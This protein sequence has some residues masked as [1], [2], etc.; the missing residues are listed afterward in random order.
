MSNRSPNLQ[1][2]KRAWDVSRVSDSHDAWITWFTH[3]AAQ[4]A[5]ES[6][7]VSL[8]SCMNLF[9]IYPDISIQLFNPALASCW[10][11]L[12]ELFQ[13]CFP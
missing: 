3:L 2:L 7:S 6:P 1:L 10:G 11:M 5:K 4:F 9:D 13:V 12:T 8:R